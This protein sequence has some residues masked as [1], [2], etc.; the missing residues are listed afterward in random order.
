MSVRGFSIGFGLPALILVALPT[1]APAQ[2][3]P[4]AQ[5]VA[6][7]TNGAISYLGVY[8]MDI[9]G[10]IAKS[11]GLKE[12]RGVLVTKV[13]SDSPAAH[14]GLQEKDIITDYNGQRVEGTTHF[15]RM[16]AETPVGRKVV[17]GVYRGGTA[18]TLTAQT[19]GRH[20][21]K[22]FRFMLETPRSPMATN[23]PMP[24]SPPNFLNGP[25]IHLTMPDIPSGLLG[26]QSSSLGYMSEPVDGQLAQFFGVQE[27]VLVR[28][29]VAKS[30][31]EK[32]GLRAGDVIIK[33]G[34]TAVRSPQEITGMLR[35]QLD[36]RKLSLIIVRSHKELTVE[37]IA[38]NEVNGDS[39][40]L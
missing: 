4:K 35:R 16:V 40:V 34:G 7:I 6:V 21:A 38:K 36:N 25:S 28:S 19:G 12:E 18:H 32:A 24:P 13:D 33:A 14:A 3:S 27:G 8:C 5:R 23:P 22:D 15:I 17:L 10:E 2:P 37:L 29:V 26:W 31:A 20:A 9:D 1:A 30:P 39:L 11:A